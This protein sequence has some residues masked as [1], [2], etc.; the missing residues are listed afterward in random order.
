MTEA[1]E[2]ALEGATEQ[3]DKAMDRLRGDRSK[4]R[5]GQA[6]PSM[7][8]GIRVDY[9]GTMTLLGQVAN[10]NSTDAR[11]LTVQAWEK[12]MLDPISTAITN[13]NLGLNPVNNGEVIIINVP[14]LTEERRRDLSKRAKGEGE[15]AKVSV[16]NARKDANDILKEAKAEGM[17]EDM[18]KTGEAK[19]QELTNSYT[20]K[21]DDILSA[22]EVDIMT[23]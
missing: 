16:R 21:I 5:A 2:M 23:V 12:Q 13:A 8:G 15:A 10:V 17:S 9:Y 7:L 19:V 14:A 22:K 20:K 4:I 18:L 1:L 11:T 6:H 3:M